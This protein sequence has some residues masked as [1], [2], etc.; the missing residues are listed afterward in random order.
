[1]LGSFSKY[2][3]AVDNLANLSNIKPIVLDVNT[4][5]DVTS[6]FFDDFDFFFEKSKKRNNQA[7]NEV[8]TP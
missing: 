1:M 5:V 3:K 8:Q 4:M 7:I 2:D 6:F